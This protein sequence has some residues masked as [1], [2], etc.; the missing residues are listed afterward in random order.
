MWQTRPPAQTKKPRT[1]MPS[2]LSTNW[3]EK[4]PWAIEKAMAAVALES[5]K[6]SSEDCT[7]KDK[8]EEDK[9]EEDEDE[10][11][12]EEGEGDCVNDFEWLE[13]KSRCDNHAAAC[14]KVAL[15]SY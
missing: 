5:G 13:G 14:R 15:L 11:D 4:I 10:E 7:M 9:G 3:R 6:P 2:G 8:G 1:K 12:E